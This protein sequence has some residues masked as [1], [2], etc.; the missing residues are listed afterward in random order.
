MLLGCSDHWARDPAASMVREWVA[1]FYNE[2]IADHAAHRPPGF[3]ARTEAHKAAR[4]VTRVPSRILRPGRQGWFRSMNIA[5]AADQS[6][7]SA[8]A[9]ASADKSE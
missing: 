6:L 5:A 7:A 2:L 3:V 8:Y 9:K 4:A 1:T